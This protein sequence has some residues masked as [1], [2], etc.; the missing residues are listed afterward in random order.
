MLE[1]VED[2]SSSMYGEIKGVVGYVLV[3]YEG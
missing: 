2:P 3:Q 1:E